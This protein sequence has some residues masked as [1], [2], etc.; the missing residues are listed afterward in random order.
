MEEVNKHENRPAI[1]HTHTHTHTYTHTHTHTHWKQEIDDD[2]SGQ[3]CFLIHFPVMS[4]QGKPYSL[5]YSLIIDEDISHQPF[6]SLSL[7]FDILCFQFLQ[8][9]VDLNIVSTVLSSFQF[10]FGVRDLFFSLSE[11]K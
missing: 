6:L 8:N 9:I 1:V 10:L 5:F 3:S 11:A 2:P 4:P 7:F